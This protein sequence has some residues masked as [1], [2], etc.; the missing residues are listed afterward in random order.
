MINLTDGPMSIFKKIHET[1][2][3][4]RIFI[5]LLFLLA[6]GIGFFWW[7]SHRPHPLA[8]AEKI[9]LCKLLPKLVNASTCRDNDLSSTV[10]AH[11]VWSNK[12]HPEMLTIDLISNKNLLLPTP[13]S[14]QQWLD[15]AMPEIKASGRQD[16]VEPIGPWSKA[17]LT[18]KE[19][20]QELLFED[21][22]VVV[23]IQ[24]D[25]LDRNTLL[26]Y[27]TETSKALRNAEPVTSSV[28]AAK[29]K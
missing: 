10:A 20:Q 26:A 18:R 21:K 23:V 16:I 14:T 7:T 5:A 8:Q 12:D 6:A 24:S 2:V 19:K 17:L 4:N 1:Q 27:A 29:S 25:V 22:G 11:S 28:A 9:P 13:I 15:F 3:D